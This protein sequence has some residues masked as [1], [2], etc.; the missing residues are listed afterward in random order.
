RLP[1]FRSLIV[2]YK[3][4]QRK[5][6]RHHEN[7]PVTRSRKSWIVKRLRQLKVKIDQYLATA[8]LF[9][10]A[11]LLSAG[12][13]PIVAVDAQSYQLRSEHPFYNILGNGAAA[14]VFMDVDA[15][16]DDDLF[17]FGEASDTLTA[18]TEAIQYYEN[19]ESGYVLGTISGYPSDL[20]LATVIDTAFLDV[21]LVPAY[22]DFDV[23]GDLDLFIGA[24][25]GELRYLRNEDGEYQ[26]VTGAEDPFDA[27]EFSP[28]TYPAFGDIDGDG[29]I[30]A[31]IGSSAGLK[32]FSNENG[33]MT[34][35][36][37]VAASGSTEQAAPL[38]FDLD[39]DG[40]LDLLVG[41]KYGELQ[42]FVN[43]A[44]TMIQSTDH[45]LVA[46]EIPGYSN[47]A[48]SDLDQDGDFDLI[49]GVSPGVMQ[50]YIN[51]NDQ[52]SELPFNTLNILSSG[53]SAFPEFVDFDGDGDEDLFIAVDDNGLQYYENQDGAFVP[54]S[55]DA[56][57][58]VAD[59]VGFP[60]PAF[61]DYDGDGD[62]DLLVGNYNDPLLLYQN[63]EGSYTLLD[64]LQNPFHGLSEDLYQAPEFVDLDNDGDLDLVVGTK[65]GALQYFTNN[66]G[67][68]EQVMDGS[69]TG[70]KVD[71]YAVPSSTDLDKDGDMD[72]VVGNSYGNLLTYLNNDGVFEEQTGADNPFNDFDFASEAAAAFSDLDGDGDID[73]LVGNLVS[74]IFFLENVDGSVSVDNRDDVTDQTGIY[75]NPV[76][77]VMQ[78]EAS[79]NTQPGQINIY[80]GKGAHLFGKP[81]NGLQT[82]IDLSHLAPGNYH[83]SIVNATK[84]AVKTFVKL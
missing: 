4:Y 22:V 58:E 39:D 48:L 50:V 75:P 46:L 5:L 80:D 34:D 83:I 17:V 38:L 72:L 29:D 1:Y 56:F 15:D 57:V 53:T 25:V 76:T 32:F 63:N 55:S 13:M 3:R 12:L 66:E 14:P 69:V 2:K 65:Y 60:K 61:G 70:I 47:L 30:D 51:D 33:V 43:D 41:N 7:R 11:A 28:D 18:D 62:L 40:D 19:Q 84:K 74:G 6:A 23:D 81:F 44:G 77:S 52:Y 16:G 36:G 79:W 67:T 64:S 73:V 20:G 26:V 27:V 49:T 82:Q 24:T 31:F 45:P 10:K 8:G 35:M 9:K 54:G 78:I 37:E 59:S 21:K 68:Y 71:G 42:V